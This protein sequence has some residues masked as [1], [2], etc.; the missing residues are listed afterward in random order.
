MH[1]AQG[2]VREVAHRG[3]SGR[4]LVEGPDFHVM[5]CC[6]VLGEVVDVSAGSVM[7]GSSICP[8]SLKSQVPWPMRLA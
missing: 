5:R 3:G 2:M 7:V 8:G 6:D 4:L 1:L